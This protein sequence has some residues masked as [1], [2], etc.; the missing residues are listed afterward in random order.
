[1]LNKICSFETLMINQRNMH[2]ALKSDPYSLVIG[3]LQYYTFQIVF[4]I[5][6]I[7][8]KR[9]KKL[10]YSIFYIYTEFLH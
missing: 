2:F 6:C 1:M 7:D 8:K 3:F 5:I 4:N 10:N 9:F